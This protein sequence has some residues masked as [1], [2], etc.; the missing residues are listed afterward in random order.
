[1]RSI[2]QTNF[3]FSQCRCQQRLNKRKMN[4]IN[5]T[6]NLEKGFTLIELMIVIAI[7]AILATIAIPSYQN[8]TK[9]LRYPNY[10]KLL[11]LIRLMWNYA[12]I[13]QAN[14]LLAQEGSNGIAADITTA[15][16]YVASVKTQSGGITVKGM[17]HWQIWNIFCK[18]KVMLQQV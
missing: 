16:G 7:I 3:S 8:Y 2:L 13:A 12:F 9:K 6:A 4:E 17:A 15:K 11:R 10:C 1:M 14:L 18:L 5:N